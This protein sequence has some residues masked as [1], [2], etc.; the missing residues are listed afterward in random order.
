MLLDETEFLGRTPGVSRTNK[1]T[2]LYVMKSDVEILIGGDMPSACKCRQNASSK[3]AWKGNTPAPRAHLFLFHTAV[4][5]WLS[6]QRALT[7]VQLQKQNISPT[8]FC[9][10]GNQNCFLSLKIVQRLKRCDRVE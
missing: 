8:P 6:K 10:S 4:H 1:N 2:H 9:Q 7:H 3:L 5:I